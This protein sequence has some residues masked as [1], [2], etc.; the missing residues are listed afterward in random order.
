MGELQDSRQTEN[1]RS[2]T[3]R[4]SDKLAEIAR[5]RVEFEGGV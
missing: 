1:G 3:A 5:Y 2:L 4:N